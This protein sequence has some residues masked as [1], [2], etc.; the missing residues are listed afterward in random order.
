M[1]DP[2]ASGMNKLV[3]REGDMFVVSDP[4]GDMA[5]GQTLGFFY[6]DMRYLSVYH[7]ALDD[8]APTLLSSSA[9]QDFMANLQFTNP[10]LSREEEPDVLPHTISLRRNRLVRDGLRERIGMMNYNRAPVQVR[11]TLELGADF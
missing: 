7:L 2:W 6:R 5:V 3:L 9:E 10:T 8:Q 11:L 1:S 4:R